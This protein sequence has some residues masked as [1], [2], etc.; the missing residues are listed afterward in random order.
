MTIDHISFQQKFVL[1]S[2]K[3]EIGISNIHW[4]SLALDYGHHRKLG[5]YY[6]VT[7]MAYTIPTFHTY[8][9]ICREIF[10]VD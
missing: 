9:S 10:L 1:F 3:E 5:Q 2:P 4:L 8:P 6:I 7:N